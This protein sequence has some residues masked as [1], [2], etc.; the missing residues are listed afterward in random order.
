MV[1][2]P[3]RIV[4]APAVIA[5]TIPMDLLAAGRMEIFTAKSAGNHITDHFRENAITKWQRKWTANIRLWSGR[6][7]G[8]VNYYVIQILSGHGYFWKYLSLRRRESNLWCRTR[9]FQECPL[10]ELSLWTDVNN[11]NDHSLTL[12]GLWL[13]VGKIDPEWRITWSGF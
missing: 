12:S 6:K 7:F 9:C 2:R 11:W 4:S 13:H 3:H 8:E 5:G 1:S 10:A